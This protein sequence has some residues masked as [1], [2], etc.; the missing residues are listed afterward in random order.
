MKPREDQK[1][2]AVISVIN[3]EMNAA[4]ASQHIGHAELATIRVPAVLRRRRV[5]GANDIAGNALP[6]LHDD[7][8]FGAQHHLGRRIAVAD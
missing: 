2:A 7:S 3:P 8:R 1:R 4:H 5:I 6:V